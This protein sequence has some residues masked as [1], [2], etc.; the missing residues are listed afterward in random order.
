M[1]FVERDKLVRESRALFTAATPL[2]L[3]ILGNILAMSKDTIIALLGI[4]LAF[5]ASNMSIR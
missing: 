3:S 5:S 1:Y 4:P 2:L